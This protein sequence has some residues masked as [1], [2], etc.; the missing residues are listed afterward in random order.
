MLGARLKSFIIV[1]CHQS[2]PDSRHV[3]FS[4]P[5]KHRTVLKAAYFPD[6]QDMNFRTL[7]WMALMLLPP[8]KLA[9]PH[10]GGVRDGED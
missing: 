1:R 2:T 4:F 9:W 8:R 5:N 7:H 10:A 3:V 6:H